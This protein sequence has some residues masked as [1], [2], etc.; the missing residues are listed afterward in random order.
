MKHD[1]ILAEE[2]VQTLMKWV[3]D[4]S[5]PLENRLMKALLEADSCIADLKRVIAGEAPIRPLDSYPIG[6]TKIS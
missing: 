5:E 2:I 4:G 1:D 6:L 3:P